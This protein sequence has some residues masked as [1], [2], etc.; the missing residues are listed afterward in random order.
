MDI[1]SVCN[2]YTTLYLRR[3]KLHIA[4]VYLKNY[5]KMLI[6]KKV[7]IK[8]V[9]RHSWVWFSKLEVLVVIVGVSAFEVI[10]VKAYISS[11]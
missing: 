7:N 10:V 6:T 1:L 9:V 4:Y 11:S 3:E 2:S 8:Y 5:I